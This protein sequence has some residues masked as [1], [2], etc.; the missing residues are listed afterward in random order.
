MKVVLDGK[1]VSLEGISCRTVDDLV[2]QLLRR[3]PPNGRVIQ[4]INID[5]IELYDWEAHRE[6]EVPPEAEV[7]VKTQSIAELLAS[8]IESAL[9]FLPRLVAA[10]IEAAELLQQGRM[11]D[12]FT[13]MGKLIEGVQWYTE[14]L[15]GLSKLLPSAAPWA[16]ERLTSL[17]EVMKQVLHCW[18][19][20]DQTLLADLLEYELAGEMEKGVEY[21]PSLVTPK[22]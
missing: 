20:Q 13:L 22:S 16:R 19:A 9:E 5:G 10:A 2:Q 17:N 3:F 1:E 11:Q 15:S 8:T 12:A 7:H 14:F 6:A 18:E 21:L 4:S